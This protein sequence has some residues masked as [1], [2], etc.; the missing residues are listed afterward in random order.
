MARSKKRMSQKTKSFKREENQSISKGAA[1][2]EISTKSEVSQS[3]ILKEFLNYDY[4]D[5][6]ELLSEDKK[7]IS[8]IKVEHES[9]VVVIKELVAQV[10][11][12]TIACKYHKKLL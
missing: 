4:D 5:F 9:V 10:D 3:N 8:L 11:R 2:C 6:V 7:D 1:N 12:L